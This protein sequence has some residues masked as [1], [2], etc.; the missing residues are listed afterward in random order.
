M[1]SKSP[2]DVM[3]LLDNSISM[4]RHYDN[5]CMQ[6][7]FPTRSGCDCYYRITPPFPDPNPAYH[8]N[9]DPVSPIRD[10]VVAANSFVDKLGTSDRVA[11]AHYSYIGP[12][13]YLGAGFTGSADFDFVKGKIDELLKFSGNKTFVWYATYQAIMYAVANARPGIKPTV[14]VFTDGG[15]TDSEGFHGIG[16]D[17]LITYI[18]S[19]TDQVDVYT[20]ALGAAAVD[21]DSLDMIANAGGGKSFI[22]PT[23]DDLDS[24]YSEVSRMIMTFDSTVAVEV[25]PT[26]AMIFDVLPS[27][28]NFV[29][30]SYR[31]AFNN[32]VNI[33]N[34]QTRAIGSVTELQWFIETINLNDTFEVEY[35]VTCTDIGENAVNLTKATDPDNYS[36][37]YYKN[38]QDIVKEEAFNDTTVYVRGGRLVSIDTVYGDF[39]QSAQRLQTIDQVT[40]FDVT[41]TLSLY[42]KVF[43]KSSG[44]GIAGF[45][46]LG[47]VE[48]TI[49][50]WPDNDAMVV[51][52]N[53]ADY[54]SAES[55]QV[56]CMRPGNG[57][58]EVKYWDETLQAELKDTLRIVINPGPCTMENIETSQ[59]SDTLPLINF[60]DTVT[61]DTNFRADQDTGTIYFVCRDKY[62]NYVRIGTVLENGQP[63][64]QGGCKGDGQWRHGRDR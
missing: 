27:W 6:N 39:S 63:P 35:K 30:G 55:V 53:N 17:S 20:I 61:L 38:Y 57:E 28:I 58:I 26:T 51:F 21:I 9:P 37:F 32:T 56:T 29:P 14:I 50:T 15:D 2:V 18:N 23:S 36:R 7:N 46:K 3:L 49:L 19:V 64:G 24:I 47:A 41:D 12:P 42:A 34:F 22:A 45:L 40:D 60:P 62:G 52:N 13:Y 25:D 11:M 8:D 31:P 33:T 59:P 54:S 5:S 43:E 10:L 16:H 44:G 48:W 4:C 1:V